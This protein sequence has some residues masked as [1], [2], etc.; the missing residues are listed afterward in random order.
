MN[1]DTLIKQLDS[2]L[3][4]IGELEEENRLLKEKIAVL[5]K[6]SRTS[7]KP[8]SSDI[9]S[10]R[11]KKSKKKRKQGGQKGR[12]GVFRNLLPEEEVDEIKEL[13]LSS[14]PNCGCGDSEGGE[15][16]VLVQQTVE[17]PERPIEVI[18]YRRHGFYCKSCNQ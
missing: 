2:A 17:L 6:T 10:A 16:K 7:S 15:E 1:I 8:P 18:E 9:T 5:E 13:H 4:R 3:K 12:K 14:C 11:K